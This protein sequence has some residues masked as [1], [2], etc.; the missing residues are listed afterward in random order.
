[1]GVLRFLRNRLNLY[2][3]HFIFHL[4]SHRWTYVNELRL[5]HVLN[6]IHTGHTN[7]TEIWMESGFESQRTFNRVFKEKFLVSPR[8]YLKK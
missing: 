1:M 3:F 4:T 2:N 6:L 5:N 8:D 7:I